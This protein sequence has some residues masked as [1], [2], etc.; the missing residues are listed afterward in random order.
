MLEV[1]VRKVAALRERLSQHFFAQRIGYAEFFFKISCPFGPRE[2]QPAVEQHRRRD[3][4]APGSRG[5]LQ[6]SAPVYSIH[7][8]SLGFPNNLLYT[9]RQFIL[10]VCLMQ[11]DSRSPKAKWGNWTDGR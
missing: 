1:K 9:C 7:N 10:F 2:S 6:K 3:Y 5:G 11:P 8:H 4:R